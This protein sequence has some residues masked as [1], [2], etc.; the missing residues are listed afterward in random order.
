M[1]NTVIIDHDVLG[2]AHNNMEKIKSN[3]S[4]IYQI[5]RNNSPLEL[6]NNNVQDADI[7]Y[8]CCKHNCDLITA[9]KKSYLDWFNNINGI[10]KLIISKYDYWNGGQRPIIRIEIQTNI[11]SNIT[12]NQIENDNIIISKSLNN[13]P[14]RIQNKL[15]SMLK[16]SLKE[17]PELNNK[18]I[19]LGITYANDGNAVMDYKKPDTFTIRL[20]PRRVTYFT[21]GHELT[22]FLQFLQL[23]PQGEKASDIFTLAK[24]QLFLDEP[25]S[26][27]RIPKRLQ[28][29]WEENAFKI[30]NLSKDALEY[31][32]EHRNYIKWLEN[33]FKN[34]K[35]SINT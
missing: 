1:N 9:D 18:K 11:H 17:F 10:D 23:A 12:Q 24:S 7:A 19:I 25:P 26:Y 16:K 4:I 31:R 14:M 20:N 6:Q 2:W 22:H 8:Y 28:D 13:A 29:Y 34:Y 32:K 27:L 35:L 21:V 3:Y 15:T 33:K 30:H 5:G